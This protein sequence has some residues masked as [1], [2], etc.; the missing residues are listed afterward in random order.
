MLLPFFIIKIYQIP[1]SLETEIDKLLNLGAQHGHEVW[2]EK[3]EKMGI[4][5]K[6]SNMLDV[7]RVIKAINYGYVRIFNF[8][9][10]RKGDTV[11][12]FLSTSD[13][14][15]RNAIQM[16]AQTQ[17]D[18]PVFLKVM[19]NIFGQ[20]IINQS[21]N[22]GL[23]LLHYAAIKG[24][25]NCLAFL[26]KEGAN[27]KKKAIWENATVT[28]EDIIKSSQCEPWYSQQRFEACM[29]ALETEKVRRL[30]DS[31]L[32]ISQLFKDPNEPD[33]NLPPIRHIGLRRSLVGFL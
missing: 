14:T 7:M 17:I 5:F 13:F 21:D 33:H 18:D 25:A 27:F 2:F 1:P 8:L 29:K 26:L 24:N 3:S 30:E 9:I 11:K 28:A 6:K 16:S 22:K 12:K 15:D 32:G 19:I 10:D 31:H 23:T 4:D 20:G